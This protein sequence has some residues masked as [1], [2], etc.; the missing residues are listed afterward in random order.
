[1]DPETRF[2]VA[3]AIVGQGTIVLPDGQRHTVEHE[4]RSYSVF[5]PGQTLV[6]LPVAGVAVAAEA[7]GLDTIT[8]ARGARFL[9]CVFVM[10]AFGVLTLLGHVAL[11]R[12]LGVGRRLALGSG[13]ILAFGTP[14]WIWGT[15]ASEEATL[16]AI[17]VWTFW[18]LVDADR[19]A[20]IAADVESP[21]E[22]SQCARRFARGI[23][24]A[25]V[26]LAFGML[27][28][29]TFVSV[30][31]GAAVMGA[32]LLI[33]HRALAAQAL[34]R[35][36][37]WCVAAILV[38]SV[39]PA[40]NWMRFD[41]PFDTGY[42]RYYES[43]GGLFSNNPLE[44]L[45]GHLVS[46]GKS[47]FLYVPWLILI[48]PALLSGRVRR[49][50]SLF[51][52][53]LLVAVGL[54]LLI[55]STYTYWSGAW[56]WF[57]RFHVSPLPILL[58]PIAVWL[59]GLRLTRGR[60]VRLGVLAGVSVLIQLAGNAFN[61]GLEHRQH[62][63][64]HVGYKGLIPDEAAWTWSASQL[65]LRLRNIAAK[66]SG[67]PLMDLAPDDPVQIITVWN[68]FPARAAVALENR[69]IVGVLWGLWWA[70]L[71][72]AL[73]AAAFVRRALR[74]R[75]S[76]V[77]MRLQGFQTLMP[78]RVREVLLVASRY[79]SFILEEEGQL[80]ELFLKEYDRLN[81]RY[82]P[83]LNS[84][85]S[86]E[87]ALEQLASGRRFDMVLL[88]MH[89]GAMHP[90]DFAREVKQ[91]YPNLP[92]VL[93][94]YDNREFQE[95]LDSEDAAV[96][97][98]VFVWTGDAR[99]LL[100]IV[101]IVED[102]M[103]VEHDT[104]TVGVEVIIFI[105]DSVHFV[106]SM[107]P[108]LYGKLMKQ[109][110]RLISEG[111]TVS[112][113]VLRMR[114]RPKILLA[115]TFEDGWE[116]YDRY[117][118]NVL[119]VISDMRFSRGGR[120]D[121]Q[122][123]AAFV[124]RVRAENADIPILL[125]STDPDN[126][127][128]AK[129]LG[130][131]FLRKDAPHLRRQIERFM[132]GSF[133]FGVFVFRLPGGRRV[134]EANNLRELRRCLETVPAESIVYHSEGQHFSTWLKARTEFRLA[135]ALRPRQVSD[136][137]DVEEMRRDLI[138]SLDEFLR[139]SHQDAISDFRP[140]TF[141]SIASF[142]RI[143]GGSL[144]GKARGL[145]FLNTL[146]RERG[147]DAEYPDVRVHVPPTA[148]IGTEHFDGFLEENGLNDVAGRDW[149]DAE[150]RARFI[151][152]R[153]PTRL[154]RRLRGLVGV[155]H[156]PVAV[157]SSSLLED[158]QHQPFAG[159]YETY[160][161]ANSDPD[162]EARLHQLCSAIKLVYASSF[163]RKAQAYLEA[164]PVRPEKEKMAVMIQ[165]LIGRPHAGRFYPTFAGVA[166]S[167][168]YY[169]FG[170]VQPRDG[171][172]VVALGLGR[173]VVEGSGGLQFC[174]RYPRHL[175]Q[176]ST[177]E[178]MLS[179]TQ[180]VFD[181]LPLNPPP[182]NPHVRFQPDRLPLEE[183]REDALVPLGSIYDR[184]ARAVHDGIGRQGVP[185]VTFA[186]ILKQ[187][188]FPLPELLCELLEIG[189]SATMVP[190]E[191]EFAVDLPRDGPAAFACLQMR[192]MPSLRDLSRIDLDSFDQSEVLCRSPRALGNGR[193]RD[194]RDVVY[195][196]PGEFDR[197]DS[198]ATAD[199][200]A[201]IN[202]ELRKQKRPYLLVGPGRW[203]SA[204]PLLGIPVNWGQIA[205]A[206][207]IVETALA[208]VTVTPSEGSHFF[209]N[210]TAFRVGYLT[211]DPDKIGGF[212]DWAWLRQQE[213]GKQCPN[214]LRWVRLSEPLLGLI[215]GES[216]A[217]VILKS[218]SAVVH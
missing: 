94:G 174:P 179:N 8:A 190:V 126:A 115:S 34:P 153:L 207:I 117:R 210:M 77:S 31:L 4:G 134:A 194:V 169:P 195:V 76:R 25:G 141:G 11:L 89:P 96:F 98:R 193:I 62:P 189:T 46:P 60:R 135:S 164:T 116:M 100:A 199:D 166:R 13:A 201:T 192:P 10:T 128:I 137:N 118:Q 159:V 119:G 6:F 148:V 47:I 139:E 120:M 198:I 9:A 214:G 147:L 167:Y 108:I 113:K 175:P 78:Y 196:E 82:A 142:S 151:A 7:I 121:P 205:G 150:I 123:G 18:G 30:A 37:G 15:N 3:E 50:I 172:A 92:V 109:S 93:L 143:G 88:T 215:D 206:Q 157:R 131:G 125:Q 144:G 17:A 22:R 161:L 218:E 185:L 59:D 69:S 216:R 106:S 16:A 136:Y 28:R 114:A 178:D 57:V 112:H 132:L 72:G 99:I 2:Q 67:R 212:I 61:G 95:L 66:L 180:R 173:L 129:K 27:H 20:R 24:L 101:S 149:T 55:Y 110:Q 165:K 182:G 19:A 181:A 35:L 156:Y 145:A 146:L 122:A 127:A 186:G 21:G 68:I 14:L 48:V 155:M 209:H 204:D 40:Y 171:A 177:V 79:D 45:V 90:A 26:L 154:V 133:G 52:W 200:I 33:R 86:A 23:G 130:V 160:M 83:R 71:A 36:A 105:E 85:P 41:D 63:E 102:A 104:R 203:G 191:I 197:R 51:L 84:T 12:A 74:A 162:E 87:Q 81:L 56:G 103:N 38:A 138:D 73:R 217:A 187:R 91:R 176:L 152:A 80:T 140:D 70:L 183:A 58:V 124:E 97:D 213:V 158:S 65:P 42:A 188:M 49:R 170:R 75:P 29:S 111:I 163:S 64:H 43:I 1:V 168:N 44:G 5:F 32:V 184:D 39:V 53:G 54:H 208:D 211:A 202:A 107:L